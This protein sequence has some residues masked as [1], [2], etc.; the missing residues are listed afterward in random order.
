MFMKK[1]EVGII[2]VKHY[3][4]LIRNISEYFLSNKEEQQLKLGLK[5]SSVDKNKNKKSY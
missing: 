1:R 5:H 3:S 2:W 4:V